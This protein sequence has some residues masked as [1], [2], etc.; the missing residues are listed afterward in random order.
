MYVKK[1]YE[2]SRKSTEGKSFTRRCKPPVVLDEEVEIDE[3][4][5]A[6]VDYKYD[7]KVVKIS[8]KNFSQGS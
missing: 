3:E 2:E 7:G 5:L 4:V 6:E 8:K 1:R